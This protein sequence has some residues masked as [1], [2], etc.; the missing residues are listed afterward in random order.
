[1]ST[2][3]MIRSTLTC[4][5]LATLAFGATG[6]HAAELVKPAAPA[7]S[8]VVSAA[9]ELQRSELDALYHHAG[10]MAIN[11]YCRA[12]GLDQAAGIEKLLQA[13]LV[14]MRRMAAS[15]KVPADLRERM[16]A[17]IARTETRQ[18]EPEATAPIHK[19]L[20]LAT[21]A[22]IRQEC[23]V[24]RNTLVDETKVL[25]VLEEQIFGKQ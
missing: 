1:M 2:N 6:A 3:A 14:F 22:E 13:K 16:P 7:A 21:D 17:V 8:A 11:Q 25:A 5:S 23:A 19:K 15:P 4:L 12:R 24:V 20:K 18:V 10:M 9:P